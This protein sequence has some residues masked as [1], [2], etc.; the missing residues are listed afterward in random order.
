MKKKRDL[1]TL[2]DLTCEKKWKSMLEHN[3]LGLGFKQL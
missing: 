3:S 1:G 2:V